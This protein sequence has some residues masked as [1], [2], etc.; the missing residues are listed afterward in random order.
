MDNGLDQ[1][2]NA[3]NSRTSRTIYGAFLLT[4]LFTV[5]VGAVAL[6][7]VR[8]QWESNQ[9]VEHTQVVLDNLAKTRQSLVDAETGQRG[10]MITAQDAYLEPYTTALGDIRD[11]MAQLRQLTVDD[12][13]QQGRMDTLEKLVQTRLER[14]AQTIRLRRE[15]GL[16]AVIQTMGLGRSKSIM[17][18]IRTLLND[19]ESTERQLLTERNNSQNRDLTATVS[20]VALGVALSVLTAALA[21]I[22][23]RRDNNRRY[24]AERALSTSNRQLRVANDQVEALAALGDALQS[25]GTVEQVARVT[26]DRVGRMLGVDYLA[27]SR[28]RGE[29]MHLESVW[30]TIPDVPRRVVE[31]GIHRTEGGLVWRVVE[32]NTAVYADAYPKEPGHLALDLPDHALAMEPVRDSSGQV[33]AIVTAGRP[34]GPWSQVERT[35][36]ARAATT[37]GLALERAEMTRALNEMR[38]QRVLDSSLLGV[39]FWDKDRTILEANDAFLEMVGFTRLELEDGLLDWRSITAPEDLELDERA[40]ES[41]Q[42]TGS[43]PVF[44]KD[45][46]LRDGR[47]VSVLLGSAM[48][49][50]ERIQGVSFVIDITEQK[51]A[52]RAQREIEERF[53]T[54]VEATSQIVWTT[55]ASG[56]FESEQPAWAAFTA[57]TF[58]EYVGTG[59]IDAIHPDDREHTL[60]AWTRARRTGDVYHTE[61]RLCRS[62]QEYRDMEVRAVPITEPDGAIREWIGVHTDIT[63][64]KRTERALRESETRARMLAESQKRFVSDAS[65]ELRAPLTAIQGNLELLRRYPN[66]DASDRRE[67]LVEAERESARLGRLVADLLALA[68]GDSGAAVPTDEIELRPVFLEAWAEAQRLSNAHHFELGQLENPTIIGNRDRLKQLALILLE[69]A[70]K[71]TPD[72]GTIHLELRPNLADPELTELR[73]TDTGPGIDPQDLS[74]VFERFYRADRSRTRGNDPGG[75]GLGLPI[76]KW[77]TELHGGQIQLDSQIGRGTSAI[78]QLPRVRIT[79]RTPHA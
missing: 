62:D 2:K 54:L 61:H 10:F 40:W 22:L 12:P 63:E 27:L 19:M 20:N 41:L 30:G 3:Q 47:R 5:A 69:N 43:A 33:Q 52:Q 49:N 74:H 34:A 53:R 48:L 23:L 6:L 70:I 15:M 9:W 18:Q 72:G 42:A 36:L 32:T 26:A 38:F 55:P 25:A 29:V 78:A 14:M 64:R 16:E 51:R 77:I 7:N 73:V 60:E 24:R 37:L 56:R 79:A 67:A 21:V 44:E 75:T 65:H 71:Y 39:N 35:M 68:R 58:D 46:I 31:R 57:Q 28:K 1:R 50:E 59:W 4:G 17:D 13:V 45:Y 76:A 8:Q 66:M 11:G